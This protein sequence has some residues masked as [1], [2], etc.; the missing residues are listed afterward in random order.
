MI[1]A[2]RSSDVSSRGGGLG[3]Q[4]DRGVRLERDDGVGAAD[5]L[6]V[7]EVH[8][9]ERAHRDPPRSALGVLEA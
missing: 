2:L 6:A 8:A 7:P 1:A 3:V 4:D 9:V 5:D